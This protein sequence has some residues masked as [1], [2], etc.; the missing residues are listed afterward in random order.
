MEPS[1]AEMSGHDF[2]GLDNLWEIWIS[3]VLENVAYLLGFLL[4]QV[5]PAEEAQKLSLW[6]PQMI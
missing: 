2:G 6:K 1:Q 4:I 3:M 5:I